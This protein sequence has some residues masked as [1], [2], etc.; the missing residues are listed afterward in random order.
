[1][2]ITIP[3]SATF[4]GGN[5]SIINDPMSGKKYVVPAWIEVPKDT[6]WNDIEIIADKVFNKDV[7]V[8]DSTPTKHEVVGSKGDVYIVTLD[9]VLGDSCNCVGFGYYKKCKHIKQVKS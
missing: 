6:T 9:P 2:V 4:A 1:M 8:S 7:P 3:E 5:F